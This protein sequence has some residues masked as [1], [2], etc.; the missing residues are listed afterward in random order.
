LAVHES[1]VRVEQEALA[2]GHPGA[3]VPPMRTEH[4]H[5]AAGHVLAG[6]VAHPFDDG[7]G[8]RV[9]DGEALARSARDVELAPGR[10]VQ[11][12]VPGKTRLAGVSRRRRDRD[13]PP[14]HRLADVVVGVTHERELDAGSEEGAE[15]LS[16]GA[17]E[18]GPHAP[19]GC[20][21][22]SRE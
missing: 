22:P 2:T 10:A 7:D 5:R 15:A 17:L 12:G 9:A 21:V 18:P 20:T 11:P 8:A 4:D 13:P 14:A 3:E 1:L 19:R 6:V 16:G